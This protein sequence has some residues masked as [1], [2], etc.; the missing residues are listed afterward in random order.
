MTAP[1]RGSEAVQFVIALPL[2]L[3]VVFGTMQLGGMELAASQLSSEI[4]R[5]CRQVDAGGLS[6]AADKE[7]FVK[8]GLLGAS[9]QL[10]PDRLAVDAVQWR[11]VRDRR[12]GP[13]PGGSVE[14]RTDRGSLEYDVRYRIPSILALP[15]M[16]ER[17]VARHVRSECVAGR[18]VELSWRDA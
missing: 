17:S 4:T 9:T 18:V 5:A 10:S 11:A 2:L 8:A 16:G 6:Q 3:L 13:L 1:E 12:E 15:G 7:A 14:E